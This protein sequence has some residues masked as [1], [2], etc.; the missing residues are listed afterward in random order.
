MDQ[1]Y[2]GLIIAIVG[3]GIVFVAFTTSMFLWLRAEAN[4]DRRSFQNNIDDQFK[5]LRRLERNFY[6]M[7]R[8]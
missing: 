5:E 3:T 1:N 2:L 8:R 4:S 6:R 7:R